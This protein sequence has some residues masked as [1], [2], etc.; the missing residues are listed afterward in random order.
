MGRCVLRIYI[1]RL[2]LGATA[3]TVV[4]CGCRNITVN[5]AGIQESTF[6][7]YQM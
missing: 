2:S 3:D 6:S 4:A 7:S 5:A 1:L